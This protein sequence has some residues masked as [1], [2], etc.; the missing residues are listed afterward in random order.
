MAEG[1]LI[2]EPVTPVPGSIE[3]DGMAR[4]LPGLPKRFLWRGCEYGVAQVL[5]TWKGYGQEGSA[6][7]LRRHWLELITDSG[8]RMTLYCE[9]QPRS[10]RQ[11]KARWWLYTIAEGA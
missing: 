11:A 9:R 1:H 6:T 2:S 10:A 8:E 7:Y 5:R 3:L 4:G